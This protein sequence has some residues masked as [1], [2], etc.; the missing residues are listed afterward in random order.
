MAPICR[1]HPGS[2]GLVDSARSR[3]PSCQGPEALVC[4]GHRCLLWV[5]WAYKFRAL[6][7]SGPWKLKA[8]ILEAE[9][10]QRSTKGESGAG[11]LRNLGTLW[12]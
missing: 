8:D 12:A 10:H 2:F 5:V 1:V 4:S 6:G 11:A 7:R 9:G 3:C